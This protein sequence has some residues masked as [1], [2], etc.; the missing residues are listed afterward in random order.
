M[1]QYNLGM[2]YYRGDG[3]PKDRRE[4]ANWL[5]PP[6]FRACPSIG[7]EEKYINPLRFRPSPEK[8][9]PAPATFF[10]AVPKAF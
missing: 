8:T 1:A 3:A 6:R 2:R 7:D 4:A 9:E 10:L 5:R